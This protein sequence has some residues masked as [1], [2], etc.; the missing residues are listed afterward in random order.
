MKAITLG[1]HDVVEQLD[2]SLDQS[3]DALRKAPAYYTLDRKTFQKHLDE[4]RSRKPAPLVR[5]IDHAM[6][7]GA[8]IPVFLTF[9]DGA[10]CA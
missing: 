8:E 7:W 10:E 4:I 9:D 3:N 5:A 2:Q 6:Q 1:Y